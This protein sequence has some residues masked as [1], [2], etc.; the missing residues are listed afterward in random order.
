[1]NQYFNP[2][3]ALILL[4]VWTAGAVLNADEPGGSIARVPQIW[5]SKGTEYAETDSLA[6]CAIPNGR[7]LVFATAKSGHRIDVFDGLTGRFI[8]HH[9]QKGTEVGQFAYPNGIAAVEFREPAADPQEAVTSRA[10]VVVERDNAR[11]QVFQP[12]GFKPMGLFGKE[13]LHKPYGCAVSYHEG[14]VMLYVTDTEVPKDK[15]VHQFELSLKD[16]EV[17]AAHVRSFGA[18]EGKGAIGEAE[19]V[20]VDDRLGLLLLCDEDPAQHNVKV[21]N[22]SGEFEGRTFGDGLVEGDP[23]GIALLDAPGD[24]LV[25]LTDQRKELTVWHLFDRKS[26]RHLDSFTGQPTIANTDGIC[27]YPVGFG[28]FKKGALFAVHDDA[29]VRAYSLADI[30]PLAQV[31]AAEKSEKAGK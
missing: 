5:A 13:V 2:Q 9:G 28:P 7:V 27:V 23:E 22:L 17:K 11:V 4:P 10:I 1:M 3:L 14:K 8:R 24:G 30:L 6:A 18:P 25:V 26:Y 31:R 12:D 29:E 20:V 19:S 16:Q 15:T 21:Y